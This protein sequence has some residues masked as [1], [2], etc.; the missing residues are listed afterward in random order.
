MLPFQDSIT[1]KYVN[2]CDFKIWHIHDDYFLK[3][4]YKLLIKKMLYK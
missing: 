2:G 1:A 4:L 3:M